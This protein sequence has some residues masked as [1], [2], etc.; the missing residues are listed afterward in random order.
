[1]KK[2]GCVYVIWMYMC[3][4]MIHVCVV[5]SFRSELNLGGFVLVYVWFREKRM[6]KHWQNHNI[7]CIREHLSTN[8]SFIFY[9]NAQQF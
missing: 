2:G 3:I 4:Y 5:Y 6:N 9:L 8:I 1:M 7:E